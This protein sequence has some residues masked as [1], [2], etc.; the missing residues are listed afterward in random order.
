M[1]GRPPHATLSSSAG[2]TPRD[3]SHCAAATLS[4]VRVSMHTA[5][6][7]ARPPPQLLLQLPQLPSC[8]LSVVEQAAAVLQLADRL[9]AASSRDAGAAVPVLPSCRTLLP[10]LPA[11]QVE[12]ARHGMSAQVAVDALQAPL[13]HAARGCGIPR[14]LRHTSCAKS[15]AE[16]SSSQ[17]RSPHTLW[18]PASSA[19]VCWG[20]AT[21]LHGLDVA[22]TSSPD[23]LQQQGAGG[24]VG[25]VGPQ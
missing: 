21:V 12:R 4:P 16:P 22:G 1:H 25:G 6:R 10:R 8:H 13:Q 19:S 2:S 3:R 20:Q 14:L 24:W 15:A 18:R 17:S 7:V 9:M 5:A 23:V 11:A